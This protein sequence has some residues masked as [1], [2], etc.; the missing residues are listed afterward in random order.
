MMY[1]QKSLTLLF[2]YFKNRQLK[3]IKFKSLVTTAM[4]SN[5]L[6]LL[7]VG[8]LLITGNRHV[9]QRQKGPNKESDQEY[10]ILIESGVK[11]HVI[12][13]QAENHVDLSIGCIGG[14]GAYAQ[15]HHAY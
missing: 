10:A 4:I 14:E 9:D 6:N 13:L 11:L 8:R 15:L 12:H 7:H 5:L 1:E 2:L 3:S